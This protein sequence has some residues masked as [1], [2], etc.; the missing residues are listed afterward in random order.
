MDGA[1]KEGIA[2]VNGSG[3]IRSFE[4]ADMR[5]RIEAGRDFRFTRRMDKEGGLLVAGKTLSFIKEDGIEPSWSLDWHDKLGGNP[6]CEIVRIADSSMIAVPI[7]QAN[8][9]LYLDRVVLADLATQRVFESVPVGRRGRKTA[10]EIGI[11][12]A[13][14]ASSSSTW[15]NAVP[16]SNSFSWN[17]FMIDMTTAMGEAFRLMAA[18][19]PSLKVSPDGRFVYALSRFVNDVTIID[20]QNR[21]VT[22]TIETG[23]DS[24]G[25]VRANR[26]TLLCAWAGKR[27]TWIN[28]STNQVHS[29]Q[30]PC[31]GRFARVQV[32]PGQRWL[33]T[34]SDRCAMFWDVITGERVASIEELGKPRLVLSQEPGEPMTSPQ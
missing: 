22:A 24:Q 12:A 27:L 32:E 21:T 26:G 13:A 19:N 9:V 2:V 1:S 11:L 7:M 28:M 16:G 18:G 20:T 30:R 5:W 10:K 8:Q 15:S 6:D 4:G 31:H 17:G 23:G 3:A 14:V 34:F 25:L 29:T 33:V